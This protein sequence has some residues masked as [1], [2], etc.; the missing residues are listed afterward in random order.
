MKNY[1]GRI[2]FLEYCTVV[3]RG[4]KKSGYEVLIGHCKNQRNNSD[5]NSNETDKTNKN[6]KKPSKTTTTNNTS[7]SN[8]NNLTILAP[9]FIIGR[10]LLCAAVTTVSGQ[11]GYQMPSPYDCA[12]PRTRIDPPYR[13]LQRCIIEL[14]P[15]KIMVSLHPLG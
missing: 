9:E 12:R 13:G 7:D 2:L 15:C 14:F 10:C 4:G 5:K 6:K 1:E 11:R 8:N 3:C